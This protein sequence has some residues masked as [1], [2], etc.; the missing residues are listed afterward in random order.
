MKSTKNLF[1][2]IIILLIGI[3]FNSAYQVYAIE[4]S[5][6]LKSDIEV[7]LNNTPIFYTINILINI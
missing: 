4:K 2:F 7:L 6:V 1:K 5:T 3:I